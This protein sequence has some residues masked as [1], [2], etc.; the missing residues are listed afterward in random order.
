M[1]TPSLGRSPGSTRSRSTRSAPWRM[2]PASRSRHSSEPSQRSSSKWRAASSAQDERTDSERPGASRGAGQPGL[3]TCD[4]A[5]VGPPH[6]TSDDEPSAG[7]APAS[8]AIS[9][10]G[11]L[12]TIS[13]PAVVSVNQ[14]VYRELGRRGWDVTIV[15]PARWRSEYSGAAL[16]PQALPGLETSLRPT[17]VALA[18]R[19]QRHFYLANVRSLCAQLRPDVAFIEA[20]PFSLAA[21]QWAG[22]L[23]A[24]EIPFGV[25]CGENICS[26]LPH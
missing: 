4:D 15:V 19:P 7:E 6:V 21:R 2:P 8:G 11:R 9:G 14:E 1:W 26:T 20:E 25:Q 24:L 10:T 13:H 23:A 18:G 5:A 17:R 12:L 3:S 22:T 16:S